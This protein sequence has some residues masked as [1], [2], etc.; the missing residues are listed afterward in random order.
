[1]AVYNPV[2]SSPPERLKPTTL[3]KRETC[4]AEVTATACGTA[5]VC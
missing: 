4:T 2:K 5:Y 1:M 3:K